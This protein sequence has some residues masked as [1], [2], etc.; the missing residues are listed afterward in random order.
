[1]ANRTD[2]YRAYNFK[3]QIDGVAQGHFTECSGLNVKIASIAY[4]ETG[5][6]VVHKLPG[7]VEYGD[8]T[9]KYGLTSSKEL[10]TWMLDTAKGKLVRKNISIIMLDNDGVKPAFQWNLKDTWPSG[11]AGAS[12]SAS[13]KDAAIESITL[14][15]ES[16]ERD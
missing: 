1:M 10:W 2:P 15:F 16:L 14:T 7:P 13:G 5:T 12:L 8:I 4:R 3:L 6:D 11:W 9:L